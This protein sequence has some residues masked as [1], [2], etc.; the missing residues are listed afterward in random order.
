MSYTQDVCLET[1]DDLN[2]LLST[3]P[4]EFIM[5]KFQADWCRPC[6]VLNPFVHKQV[7]QKLK[8]M[9]E[10]QRKNVFL[11]VDVNVDV[12]ID[13]YAFLKQK[14]RING[15]PA[16]FLYSKKIS[17]QMDRE[18]M[19]IPHASVTGVKEGEIKKL[20]DCIQ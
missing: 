5:L 8:E 10:K 19:Y 13:L 17:A 12:C 20:F 9:D 7:T 16:I 1:R 18:H 11:Y 15:I 2:E 14:K 3:T 4:Y 6:K